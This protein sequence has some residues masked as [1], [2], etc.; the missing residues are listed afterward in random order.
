MIALYQRKNL[1]F[2]LMGLCSLWKEKE[3]VLQDEA[4]SIPSTRKWSF[5]NTRLVVNTIVVCVCPLT[6]L[7]H[8][9]ETFAK[10]KLNYTCIFSKD[11]A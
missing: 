1:K 10:K 6:T 3:S 7:H 8:N 11:M 2:Q 5:G 4:K 9:E